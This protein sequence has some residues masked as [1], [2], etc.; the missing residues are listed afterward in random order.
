[1]KI[2][3]ITIAL[4][5]LNCNLFAQ[6]PSTGWGVNGTGITSGTDLLNRN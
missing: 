6:Q 4:V 2:K 3:I 1:M 5:L